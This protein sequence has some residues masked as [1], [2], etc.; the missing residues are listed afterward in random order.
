MKI[1]ELA[2]QL[3]AIYDEHG[4]IDVFF[5]GPNMD[6]SPYDVGRA[7]VTVAEEDEYPKDFNMPAG[8]KF[9]ELVH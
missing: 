5:R 6:T 4:D 8:Y 3:K 7:Q 2:V 9:V 1:F